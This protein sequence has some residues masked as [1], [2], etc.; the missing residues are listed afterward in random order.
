MW[1]RTNSPSAS[2][3]WNY[4]SK[5]S[6]PF[7]S[8]NWLSHS[9]VIFAS[10]FKSQPSKPRQYRVAF[11]TPA[12]NSTLRK[13]RRKNCSMPRPSW[14]STTSSTHSMLSTTGKSQF[15]S[16]TMNE[17]TRPKASASLMISS[18][19]QRSTSTGTCP[20]KLKLAGDWLK[21]LGN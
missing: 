15:G 13:S 4:R 16:S 21:Q 1:P 11:W 17:T 2:R 7:P 19:F 20:A 9:L 18:S 12:G 10:I 14:A 3:C 6:K 8:K 5:A